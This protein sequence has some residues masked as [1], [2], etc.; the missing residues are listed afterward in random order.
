MDL[1]NR[2]TDRDSKDIEAIDLHA[3]LIIFR[4]LVNENPTFNY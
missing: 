3:E 4:F 1:Q 2:L